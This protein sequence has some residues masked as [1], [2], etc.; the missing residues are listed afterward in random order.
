MQT[1]ALR[2]LWATRGPTRLGSALVV[3]GVQ[4]GAVALHC[5]QHWTFMFGGLT[6]SKYLYLRI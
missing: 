5:A 1:C 2:C 3:V 6:L 4:A